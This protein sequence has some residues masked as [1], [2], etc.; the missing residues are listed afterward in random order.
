MQRQSALAR[1]HRAERLHGRR[2]DR[3][4][5]VGLRQWMGVAASVPKLKK[6][7]PAV[8]MHAFSHTLPTRLLR[9]ARS[10]RR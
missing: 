7:V 3:H 5:P 6:H 8:A 9:A 2:T 4:L 1:A 10:T